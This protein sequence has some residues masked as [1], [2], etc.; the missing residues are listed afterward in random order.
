M[1][2]FDAP[3]FYSNSFQENSIYYQRISLHYKFNDITN[4][5]F[6]VNFANKLSNYLIGYKIVKYEQQSL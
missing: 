3:F 5:N 1:I 6:V 4:C 2:P